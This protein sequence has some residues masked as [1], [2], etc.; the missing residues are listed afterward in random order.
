VQVFVFIENKFF[1][2]ARSRVRKM[3]VNILLL[4]YNTFRR[5]SRVFFASVKKTH[6]W[7]LTELCELFIYINETGHVV[8]A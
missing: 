8:M 3:F 5:H 4:Y 7:P 1:Y 2:D 6:L